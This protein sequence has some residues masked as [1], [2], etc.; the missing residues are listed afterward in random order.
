[1]S[2]MPKHV[3]KAVA[4]D[5]GVSEGTVHN[6]THVSKHPELHQKVKDGE[7]KIKTAYR[8][9]DP[10]IKKE[11]K[12]ISGLYSYI[13]K[14]I[15]LVRDKAARQELDARLADL[16]KHLAVLMGEQNE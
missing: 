13:D 3:R 6:Y 12:R 7:L 4:A 9:L 2:L 15:H 8:L 1:M 11:L 5:A 10:Q 14:N 16:Q